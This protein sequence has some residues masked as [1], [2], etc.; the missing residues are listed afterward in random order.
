MDW[1]ASRTAEVN[2]PTH[3]LIALALLSKRGQTKRNWAVLIG[4]I[5]PDII[6]YIWAPYQSLVN[7]VSGAQMWDKLYFEPPMQTAIALVNSIPIYAALAFAGWMGRRKLWGKLLLF[8]AL[9]ALIHMETDLPV[10]GHDAY[11]HFWPLS[12]WR[13]HSPISYWERDLH[14]TWVSLVEAVIA[15]ACIIILWRRFP[16]LWART[17]LSLLA[18]F[19][20]AMQL[21]LRLA[22]IDIG[23]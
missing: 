4:S 5:I 13:F 15:L 2:S 16:K 6:I 21:V 17:I 20:V 23:S 18:L 1:R 11:R 19:Y 10:H 8:F 9:A 7:G 12:D 3:S 14:S 22:A